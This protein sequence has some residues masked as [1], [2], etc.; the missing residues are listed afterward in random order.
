MLN[1]VVFNLS[2]LAWENIPENTYYIRNTAELQY[3]YLNV[4]GSK[5][6]TGTK[7]YLYEKDY[8]TGQQYHIYNTNGAYTLE[9][10]CAP[11][12]AV[13]VNTV[14]VANGNK[15]D[16]WDYTG[17]PSQTWLF[18]DVGGA[19]VIRSKDNTDC[20]LTA[21]TTKNVQITVETYTG[22]ATQKWVF[23]SVDGNIVLPTKDN[24][25]KPPSA[26]QI[27]A[28]KQFFAEGEIAYITWDEVPGALSYY[29]D[30]SRN[31]VTTQAFF[32]GRIIGVT[33]ELGVTWEIIVYATNNAGVSPASNVVRIA[34]KTA[35]V[36]LV[37]DGQYNIKNIGTGKYLNVVGS[38]S[39]Q[40]TNI[41]I[42]RLD[43]TDG[44]RYNVKFEADKNTYYI[45][46]VC[47]PGMRVNVNAAKVVSGNNV[48]IWSNTG[49]PSQRWVFEAVNEG[50]IIRSLDNN[51]CVLTA[52]GNSD[53]S[54]VAVMTYK[55]GDMNQIWDFEIEDITNGITDITFYY[56][57]REKTKVTSQYGDPRANGRRHAG[58][59]YSCQ[60]G[61]PVYPAA[62]GEVIFA[63]GSYDKG[64]IYKNTGRGE[65]VVIKH[66]GGYYTIYQHLSSYNVKKGQKII[67]LNTIIGYTGNT[68]LGRKYHLHFEIQKP[69]KLDANDEFYRDSTIAYAGVIDPYMFNNIRSQIW[70][71]SIQA[72]ASTSTVLVNGK[73]ITFQAYTINGNNYFKLR[74]LA[75]ALNSTKKQFN[76]DYIEVSKAIMLTLGRPYTPVGGELAITSGSKTMMAFPSL[77]E[78]YLNGKKIN[79]TAYTI[80]GNNYF[81]LRDIGKAMN[82]SVTWEGAS[83]TIRIDT[84]TGY[85]E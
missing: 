62:A 61:T 78:V 74:D 15:V 3:N 28:D 83:N 34:T 53:G 30:I 24:K 56:P 42:F 14:K 76:I 84:S 32:D 57:L 23:E 20:V 41:T 33:G 54:N 44:V 51:S 43:Y 63:G 22:K 35:P 8:T 6:A 60:N 1:C 67:D 81:K 71:E 80:G 70:Y 46:P 66:D 4:N 5:S 37:E 75:M 27:K 49:N 50:Y 9:P 17:N 59:D 79:L 65:T 82:F 73:S 39:R 19:Y 12:K 31:G 48:D 18:E 2:V 13:N 58:I 55:N 68:G 21:S 25:P 47:A 64:D 7:I 16:V 85:S 26:P 69:S 45:E 77:S 10:V 29:A 40:G 11:G 38:G 72:S 36:Q 52:T